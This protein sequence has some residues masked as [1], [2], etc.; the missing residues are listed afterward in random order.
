VPPSVLF[1]LARIP[2]METRTRALRLVTE[3]HWKRLMPEAFLESE[4]IISSISRHHPEWLLAK[5]LADRHRQLAYDWSRCNTP[6]KRK[7]RTVRKAGVWERFRNG[8]AVANFQLQVAEGE[9]LNDARLEAKAARKDMINVGAASEPL[10]DV[11][12]LFQTSRAGWLG[13]PFSFWR[14]ETLDNFSYYLFDVG[15]GAYFDWFST[16]VNLPLVK[17]Q[18]PYWTQFW[19][20][21]IDESEVPR[22]WIRWAFRYLTR[23]RK[24]SSGTPCDVQL[25]AYLPDADYIISIDKI[26]IELVK[27]VG[28]SAVIP[29]AKGVLISDKQHVDKALFETLAMIGGQS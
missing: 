16:R 4:E 15:K 3:P 10:R 29:L 26:M 20:Y 7:L 24:V 1:E 21:E 13:D 19:L 18:H 12:V 17:L 6:S 22:Q 23:F 9:M 14:G 28:R 11:Q 2:V 5:P 8:A 27:E 25:S